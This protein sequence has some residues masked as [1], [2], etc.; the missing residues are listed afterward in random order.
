MKRKLISGLII[1]ISVSN[2]YSTEIII[3]PSGDDDA[4]LIQHTLD[5]LLAD[6]TLLLNGDFIIAG[7]IYLPSLY[8]Y[9]FMYDIHICRCWDPMLRP[10]R[11]RDGFF[12]SYG[13]QTLL[14]RR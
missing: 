9:I 5:A 12:P 10:G 14:K 6:D 4:T 13:P 8:T 2:I 1:F 11:G 3:T 7:T